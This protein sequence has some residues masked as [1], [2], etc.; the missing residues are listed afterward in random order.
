MCF[1]NLRPLLAY[2]TLTCCACKLCKQSA[3][4]KTNY[5]SSTRNKGKRNC[6]YINKGLR[7]APAERPKSSFLCR[8]LEGVKVL[9]PVESDE[10]LFDRLVGEFWRRFNPH[11][12]GSAAN[13]NKKWSIKSTLL[14]FIRVSFLTA[15][16]FLRRRVINLFLIA[17]RWTRLTGAILGCR[18]SAI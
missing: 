9:F 5:T 3:R 17:A 18:V 2:T 8:V 11:R 12:I 13:K 14:Y 1:K 4:E 15:R 7:F 6:N 16:R 10:P